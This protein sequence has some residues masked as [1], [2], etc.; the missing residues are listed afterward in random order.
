MLLMVCACFPPEPVVAATLTH[1]LAAQL[2]A[3]HDVRVVT[4]KPSRPRGFKFEN[5]PAQPKNFE[6]I[7]VPSFTCPQASFWGRIK[8]SYSFGKHVSRYIQKHRK[9]IHFIYLCSWPLLAP[10]LILKTA[11]SCS[12][13]L[14]VHVEDMYP[15]AYTVK[16]PVVGKIIKSIL[17]PVD[18]FI[19]K[20]ASKVIAVSE[21]M[22]KHIMETRGVPAEKIALVPNWQN[23][24]EFIRFHEQNQSTTEKQGPFTFMYLG[25]IGPLAGIDFVIKCFDQAGLQGARLVIAGSGAMKKKYVEL[26]ETCKNSAIEFWDVPAGKVPEIQSFADVMILPVIQG[27]AMSSVPS[28]LPA[29]MFSKKPVI[30]CVDMQSDTA[31]AVRGAHCGWI[32]PPG[33]SDR[34]VQLFKEVSGMPRADLQ[35]LG[36]NGFNYAMENFSK[37]RNLRE[38]V[39]LISKTAAPDFYALTTSS[40]S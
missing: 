17:L 21:N 1:D 37:K 34:L 33:N 18:A 16:I 28:K 5:I 10:L 36:E 7:I 35:N 22:K 20:R 9:E 19:L 25:N 11:K 27:G 13:P 15:E 32:V 29:Y 4:P 31:R 14:I 8:E 2:S 30:A 6:Q 26:V 23:E 38:L 12:I 40:A 39:N 24:D 3:Q